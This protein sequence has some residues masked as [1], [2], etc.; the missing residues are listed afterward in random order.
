MNAI[1]YDAMAVGNH[2]FDRGVAPLAQFAEMATF[3]LLSAN[4]AVDQEPQLAQRIRPSAVFEIGGEK[5]GAVGLTTRSTP[6][7]SSPGP[8]F[9]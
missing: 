6:S 8:T 4:I 5:I 9:T 1:G 7:I 2:E 3:P